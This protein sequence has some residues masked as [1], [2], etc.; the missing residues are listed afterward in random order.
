MLIELLL[1]AFNMEYTRHLVAGYYLLGFIWFLLALASCFSPFIFLSSLLVIVFVF[2]LIFDF[3][4]VLVLVSG[5]A[6][7]SYASP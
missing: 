3:V 5:N 1:L 6:K 7:L 4:F 2:V